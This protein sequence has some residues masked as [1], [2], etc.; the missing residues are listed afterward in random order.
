MEAQQHEVPDAATDRAEEAAR[1]EKIIRAGARWLYWAA[2][3]SVVDSLARL[4]GG[5]SGLVVGLGVTRL[6]EGGW[7][8]PALA[9]ELAAPA[10]L[11]A[12]GWQSSRKRPWAFVLGLS[13]YALDGVVVVVLGDWLKLAVHAIVLLA[14]W[15]GHASLRRLQAAEVRHGVR[16]IAPDGG[17]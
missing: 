3:L 11:V 8:G 12:L 2:G 4:I 7:S 17:R 13:L 5:H 6:L 10:L 15:S 9:V 14:L 1:L 16:P